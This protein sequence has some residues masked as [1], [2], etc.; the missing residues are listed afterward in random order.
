MAATFMVM[1]RAERISAILMNLLAAD[2][3]AA[4]PPTVKKP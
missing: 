1:N 3:G 2:P 4:T